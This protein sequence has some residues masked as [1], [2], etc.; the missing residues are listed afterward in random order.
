MLLEQLSNAFIPMV[1]TE[2]DIVRAVMPEQPLNAS[3]PM[4]VT[5]EGIVRAVIP[6]Q[7]PSAVAVATNHVYVQTKCAEVR[8][9]HVL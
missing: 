9:R 2:A 6:E 4:D 8:I 7:P 5:V 1:V 3:L